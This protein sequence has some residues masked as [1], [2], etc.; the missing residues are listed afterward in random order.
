MMVRSI[1]VVALL[2]TAVRINAELLRGAS[3]EHTEDRNLGTCLCTILCQECGLQG[4]DNSQC[5]TACAYSEQPNC[6]KLCDDFV[7]GIGNRDDSYTSPPLPPEPPTPSPTCRCVTLCE[8]C[9]AVGSNRAD[10]KTVCD[11]AALSNAECTTQCNEALHIDEYY[12]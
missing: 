5:Q 8:Q 1:V 3:L 7:N 11:F 10:C 2:L 6:D 9:T 4:V 12:P